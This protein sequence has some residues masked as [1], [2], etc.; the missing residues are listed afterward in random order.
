M[1]DGVQ[2]DMNILSVAV[3][4]DRV[5]QSVPAA[6][7]DSVACCVACSALRAVL[8]IFNHRNRLTGGGVMLDGVQ[9]DF[10]IL[11]VAVSDDGVKQSVPAACE[12]SAA[13]CVARSALQAALDIFNHR[14][15][16]TGGGVMLG[17]VQGEINILSVAESGYGVKQSVPAP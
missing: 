16:L 11:S 15:R 2:G 10:N 1:L 3:S 14:N 9:G 7:E 8:Y 5:K 12:D 4:D 6:C 17:G 13:S